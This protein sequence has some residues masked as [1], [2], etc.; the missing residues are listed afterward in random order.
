LN[1]RIAFEKLVQEHVERECSTFFQEHIVAFQI[2]LVALPIRHNS[3]ATQSLQ[4]IKKPLHQMPPQHGIEKKGIG[5]VAIPASQVQQAGS[6][7]QHDYGYSSRAAQ[8]SKK[9]L[10]S[11]RCPVSS[12]I[13]ALA[14]YA[15]LN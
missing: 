2:G 15:T 3:F 7:Y 14:V 6:Q 9:I 13:A 1:G 5:P 4:E 10:T 12:V 11:A 8:Q